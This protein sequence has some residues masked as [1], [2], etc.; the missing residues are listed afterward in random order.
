M[1]IQHNL[2][3]KTFGNITVVDYN[4][5]HKKKGA[6][7]NCRCVCGKELVRSG[8]RLRTAR[9]DYSCG[10]ISLY[11]PKRPKLPQ[12]PKMNPDEPIRNYV[13]RR[14]MEKVT[15]RDKEFSLTKEMVKE[16]MDKPCEYC[17]EFRSNVSQIPWNRR[18]KE[19][20]RVYRF[21]GIDR[22]DSSKGYVVGNVV[23]S[24]KHCN[25]GKNTSSPTEYIA[26]CARVVVFQLSKAMPGGEMVIDF[27]RRH[28]ELG[29]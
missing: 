4:S 5:Y 1:N 13:A 22:L 24:C 18:I 28:F 6:M 7:W 25:W 21:N 12:K 20:G 2:A 15:H 11:P 26:H 27:L 19:P 17:G 9:V 29:S 14:I 23:P 8:H 3:G 16:M 10:C